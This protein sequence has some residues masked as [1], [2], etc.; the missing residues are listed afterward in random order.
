[1]SN[2]C[3]RNSALSHSSRVKTRVVMVPTTWAKFGTR[4]MYYLFLKLMWLLTVES[5]PPAMETK[6]EPLL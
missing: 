3:E 2:E 4:G 1:M 6:A 5:D